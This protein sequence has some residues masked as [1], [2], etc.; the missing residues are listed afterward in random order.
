MT[1]ADL[2]AAAAVDRLLR[3]HRGDQVELESGTDLDQVWRMVSEVSPDDYQ[4]TVVRDGPPRW[5]MQVTR[6]R[7]PA[8]GN[9]V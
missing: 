6:R 7:S 3:M 1:E 8:H 2:A 5:R 9:P 4:F